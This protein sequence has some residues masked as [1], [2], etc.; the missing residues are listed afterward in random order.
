MHA[1]GALDLRLLVLIL[2]MGGVLMA[3]NAARFSDTGPDAADYGAAKQYPAGDRGNFFQQQYMVGSFS[4][5]DLLFPAHTVA[6]A[7]HPWDFARD[8]EEP[9]IRYSYNGQRFG[10]ADYLSHL[11]ITGL[12]IAKDKDILFEAYQYGRT[13]SERFT[14]QSMAKT[15]VAMLAGIAVERGQIGSVNDMAS[16][17]VPEIKATPFGESSILDLLHMSSGVACEEEEPD[18]K[19]LAA[20]CRRV[21]P[22]GKRFAYSAGDSE[23]LGMAVARAV[24]MPLASDLD[25]MIWKRIGTEAAASWTIDRLGNETP[26]CCFNAVLRDYAHFGRLLANDGNWDGQQIIPKQWLLDATTVRNSEP[27]LAPGVPSRYFGYGYQVWIFPGPRRMF[28]LLGANGQRIFVDP[29]SK[30]VM[31]Q[32]AVMPGG[33]NPVKDAEM[34]HLWLALVRRYG[35]G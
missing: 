28:A 24:H 30:L 21:A 9:Q 23:L 5:F 32:T 22:E 19:T 4:H 13:D 18:L 27:Q 12:L 8:P 15:I 31:V 34:I 6:A 16:K 33:V 17:Y 7:A 26:Y 10:L 25:E 1:K 2:T 20:G 3:G 29:E 35:A 14:S 11:P